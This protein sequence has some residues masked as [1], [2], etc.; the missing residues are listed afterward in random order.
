MAGY[1]EKASHEGLRRTDKVQNRVQVEMYLSML[2]YDE[3]GI[4]PA[5]IHLYL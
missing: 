1:L 2:G 4:L 3:S 5:V